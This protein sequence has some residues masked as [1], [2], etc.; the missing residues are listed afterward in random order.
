MRH[1]LQRGGF[2]IVEVIIV[3]AVSSTLIMSGLLIFSGRR[4]ST[5]FR[6][7]SREIQSQIEDIINNVTVGYYA[8]TTDFSCS[9]DSSGSTPTLSTTPTQQGANLECVFLGRAVQFN[10][11]WDYYIIYN[12][13]G[14]RTTGG[15][16]S[17][18]VAN[19][20]EAKPILASISSS[21]SS[22]PETSVQQRL[23]SFKF[24]SMKYGTGLSNDSSAVAFISPFPGVIGADIT[25]GSPVLKMYSASIPEQDQS[26]F[27]DWFRANSTGLL[28][29]PQVEICFDSQSTDQS[30]YVTIGGS[31]QQT[32][33]SSRIDAGAC[34]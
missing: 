23:G 30:F 22:Y 9:A 17:R 10:K 21:Q 7:A 4:Q 12:I 2:T 20:V 16:F 31:N 29:T 5:E 3:L 13:V 34:S 28:E 18:A 15:V 8:K 19:M 32:T 6:Q 11:N 27:V 33:T 14:R 1:T 25:S 24:G 26:V